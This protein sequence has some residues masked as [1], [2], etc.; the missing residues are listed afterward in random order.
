[1][2]KPP[3]KTD[4]TFEYILVHYRWVFV[5]F[6]LL[7]ISFFYDIWLYFRNWI[8]FKISSAP[9]KHNAKVQ[10]VQRQVQ[11]WRKN[12]QQTQM[13]TARPG[14]QTV[15]FRRP[16]YKDI[17]HKVEVNLVDIL[18]INTQKKIIRVEPLVTMGQLTATINPLGWTLPIVPEIDDLTVGG[19]VMGTGIESSSHHYGLF[20][21]ICTAFELVTG[22]GGIVRCTPDEHPDLFRAVPWSYGTVGILTAVEIN[23]IPAK[24]Y[25]K[26]MYEPI[27]S[28]KVMARKLAEVSQVQSQ[29]EFVEGLMFS[30]E[31]GVLMTA[32]Q[33]DIVEEDKINRI[34]R[35][36][37]PWFFIHVRNMLKRRENVTEYIPLRD[38]YHRHTRSIFWELQDIIPFGNNPVF[39]YLFGWI[40]PPKIS[41]LKLTQTDAVKRLY[42]NNHVIQDMLVPMSVFE[43][44]VSTFHKAFQVYPLWVCPFTLEQLPGLVHPALKSGSQPQLYVDIGV[45]GVP[46]V[47]DFSPRSS[48]RDIES[49]VINKHGFQ[50]LYA[51]TYMTRAEFR[52]M[53]D[54]KLYD[55]VREKWNC[56]RAFPEVYDKVSK[57]ARI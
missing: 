39:R 8:V 41:L 13:C 47:K 57:E 46:K 1:M 16:R 31:E 25:V 43:E 5:C 55:E 19:L 37:K 29:A 49:F 24:K 35:W 20:Q 52:S 44:S 18:E 14:W 30:Q 15:S 38:Y 36:Y 51:D 7:P 11:Q 9:K 3:T 33:T 48:T 17:M 6:F 2:S 45:Y 32:N 12:G 28:C 21:H 27:R 34:A 50:M 10:Y 26:I 22:D 56:K 40:V 42:E 54:H 4:S 53:F 23:I